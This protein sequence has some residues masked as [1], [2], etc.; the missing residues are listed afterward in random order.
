MTTTDSPT[1]FIGVWGD[2]IIKG[3]GTYEVFFAPGG[4]EILTGG[5]SR[6]VYIVDSEVKTVEVTNFN[7]AQDV[8]DVYS[9]TGVGTL[10]AL[11]ADAHVTS[12]GL[13]IDLPDGGKLVLDGVNSLSALT[14]GDVAFSGGAY[15]PPSL[16][17]SLSSLLAGAT[18]SFIVT[19][20]G[21]HTITGSGATEVFFNPGG[22]EVLT[23]GGSRDIY[24]VDSTT[25]KLEIA[26]FNPGGDVLYIGNSAGVTSLQTLSPYAHV[27][28]AGL[29]IDLPKGAVIVLDGISS[30]S[31]LTSSDTA[32][33]AG[34]FTPPS[35][36]PAVPAQPSS[37][38]LTI[39]A[40]A[41]SLAPGQSVTLA[42]LVTATDS[43][44][45]ISDYYVYD[46]SHSIQL[47]GATNLA[48]GAAQE[49]GYV[50]VAAADFAKLTFLGGESGQVTLM[51]AVTDASGNNANTKDV[52]TVTGDSASTPPT[53]PPPATGTLTLT[54]TP[55]SVASGQSLALANLVTATDSGG[56]ITDFYVYDPS[57]SVQLNGATNLANA[58]AQAKGYVE[59][60]AADF[61]KLT[62]LGGSIGSV[63]LDIAA[64]DD[65]GQ[66]KGITETVTVTGGT[67][68]IT[69]VTV[70][71]LPQTLQSGQS[72]AVTSLFS[73][74]ASPANPVTEY[75]IYDPSHAIQL[76]GA[77]NLDAAQQANGAYAISAADLGKLT[78]LAGAAGSDQL[79]ILAYD[80]A[81]GSWA[82]ESLTVQGSVNLVGL[83]P[84][85][86]PMIDRVR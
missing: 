65:A 50:E 64:M 39:S 44:G 27:T 67:G 3:T 33:F 73:V 7:P 53:P 56:T 24:V 19:A 30:L 13:E 58:E 75:F 74:N 38:S 49:K 31:A 28:S 78:Y 34:A 47:D 70:T 36:T 18:P 59:L 17:S 32:F 80:G 22:N 40:T 63:T 12:T 46:P 29:E 83:F 69:P 37:N 86:I 15:T 16:N 11:T 6:D 21:S 77:T 68:P 20:W 14:S 51:I 79:Q 72:I 54:A 41:A 76:N 1:Y 25:Q 60:S 35:T 26:N 81:Y 52:I 57:H 2:N 43:G 4:N 82:T 42:S 84:A 71:P 85:G 10:A 55:G 8:L 23:G 45:T 66:S 62:F 61:G 5:G 9:S 48:N